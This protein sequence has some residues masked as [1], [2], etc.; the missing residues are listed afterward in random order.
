MNFPKNVVS[1]TYG[2]LLQWISFTLETKPMA[3]WVFTSWQTTLL[4]VTLCHGCTS[5]QPTQWPGGSTGTSADAAV[6]Q[7]RSDTAIE[8]PRGIASEVL[9]S[10]V[11][12]TDQPYP[13]QGHAPPNY[14]VQVLVNPEAVHQYRNWSTHAALPTGTWLVARHTYRSNPAPN[15]KPLPLY[16]MYRE[17]AGWVYGAIDEEG[18]RIP[19]A[20]EVC[21]DC[22]TQARAQSV[23]GLPVAR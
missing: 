23:F 15:P 4:L 11:T 18:I 5:R 21:H 8:R 22:H 10:L 7:T 20:T 3:S 1:Q 13:S 9:A 16:T 14:L 17:T 19:V 2:E 12:A 6:T